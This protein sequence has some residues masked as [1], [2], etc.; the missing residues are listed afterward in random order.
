MPIDY[1][2][3]LAGPKGEG[4]LAVTTH[5]SGFENPKLDSAI[6]TGP[7]GRRYDLLKHRQLP[8]VSTAPDTSI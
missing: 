2:V 3:T 5:R 6:L 7:D 1:D 4:R 8:G